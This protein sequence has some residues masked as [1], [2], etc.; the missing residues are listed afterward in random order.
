MLRV[1]LRINGTQL[2]GEVRQRAVPCPVRWSFTAGTPMPRTSKLFDPAHGEMHGSELTLELGDQI[3]LM[4]DE[5]F[6]I[7]FKSVQL[8]RSPVW[9]TLNSKKHGREIQHSSPRYSPFIS[10]PG[11]VTAMTLIDSEVS[12]QLS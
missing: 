8:R 12:T 5:E 6:R 11:C 9:H 2:I 3:Q 7:Q 10:A 1:Q 4:R